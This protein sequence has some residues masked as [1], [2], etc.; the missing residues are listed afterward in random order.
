MRKFAFGQADAASKRRSVHRLLRAAFMAL[1]LALLVVCLTSTRAYADVGIVLNESLNTSVAWV[2]G[3]GHS[4]VYFS[5]I[6][7]ASP[8]KLRL[9]RPGEQGSIVSNYTTLG[10]D[11]PYEWN[12]VPLSVYVYGA[13]DPRHRPM[14]GTPKVK[15]ELEERYREKF[16]TGYCDSESCRTSK[17]AEWREMV[18]ASLSRSIFIFV[19]E[20]SVEQDRELIAKYNSLPNENHFN[21]MTRNCA[22]FTRGVI[23]TY[24]PRAASPDY[25]NDFGM[26]SPKAIARS[27]SHYA[28][29]HPEMRF[30]V[31]HFAQVPGTIQRSTEAR[32]GTQ[33]LFRSKKLLVPMAV[34]ASYELPVVTATYLLTARFNPGR[35][36]EKHP[37]AEVTEIKYQVRAARAENDTARAEELEAAEGQGRA[38]VVGTAREWRKYRKEFNSIVDEAAR[39]R[40]FSDRGYLKS[41][42]KQLDKTA[43]LIIDDSGGAWMEISDQGETSLV[44]LSAGNLFAPGSD[45]QLAYKIVLARTDHFLRSP[46]HSR[47]TMLEFKKDWAFL[48]SARMKT[49]NAVANAAKSSP[50]VRDSAIIHQGSE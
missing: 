7:P 13:E 41:F 25:V 44:G 24:F 17:K 32:S 38:E 33:Q 21:A 47:E 39:E 23:N 6:C 30:R 27:F 12:I 4:A 26:T 8:V 18:G 43:K 37:T 19:V 35:E 40:I 1:V 11:Q 29:E 10:E 28:V 9:C 22:D 48:Q 3:S 46:K 36:L 31:L 2:T 5:R 50:D 49:A 42:F 20:T 45:P 16:L 14:F 34:F 15:R